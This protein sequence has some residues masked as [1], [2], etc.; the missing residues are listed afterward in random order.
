MD[1]LRLLYP[2]VCPVCM[3]P[4]AGGKGTVH[5]KCRK[6]HI[7]V[8]DPYCMRCGRP[9]REEKEYC[10]QCMGNI[11]PYD[12]GVCVFLY[13]SKAGNA[14]A[15]FKNSGFSELPLFFAESCVK[16]YSTFIRSTEAAMIIPVPVTPKKMRIRG[17]NQAEMLACALSEKTGIPMCRAVEK[18]K[19]TKEQKSLGRAER[20]KNLLG[21]FRVKQEML[22]AK[23]VIVVDD[24]FTTGSTVGAMALT[25]KKAGV[26][27][28]Y[29]I[30]AASAHT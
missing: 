24:I 10:E 3:E 15:A 7:Y 28:V 30:C 25:L 8:T 14:I 26:E 23:S 4:V 5:D 21:T 1:I 27:R 12:A 22:T 2:Y 19:D 13:Q 16:R 17:F 6:A 29:F 20:Q 18:V 9:M 11:L